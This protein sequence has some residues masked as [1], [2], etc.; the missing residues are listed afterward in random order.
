MIK[1]EKYLD[2][3]LKCASDLVKEELVAQGD[4]ISIR[5]NDA[6]LITKDVN[7]DSLTKEDIEEFSLNSALEQRESLHATIYNKRKDI[8][9]IIT[10]H[11]PF[12]VCVAEAGVKI[13]AVVDDIAQ[14][15]GATTKVAKTKS[16]QDTLKAL[17]SR[18]ACL[19]KD[20]GVIATGRTLDEAYT[21]SMVLEKGAKI[22]V[23]TT[24]L[25]GAK[26]INIVEAYLM[27]LIYKTKY[28]KK[29]QDAK[30]ADII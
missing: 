8:N 30:I 25:G 26:I 28:S 22:F 1:N 20:D 5:H 2:M 14:I 3:I 10:N 21:A 7:L 15:V 9:A 27:H 19:I 11:S 18:N 12:C 17:K 4:C 16:P 23:E 24:V 13:P 29:D 6:F